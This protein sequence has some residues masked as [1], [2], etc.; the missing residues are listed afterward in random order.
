VDFMTENLPQTREYDDNNPFGVTSSPRTRAYQGVV[1]EDTPLLQF[2]TL[3][4]GINAGFRLMKELYFDARGWNTLRLIGEHWSGDTKGIYANALKYF[5]HEDI[6]KP[7]N[8]WTDG[9]KIMDAISKEENT[10]TQI[11]YTRLAIGLIAGGTAAKA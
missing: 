8:F 4:D 11:A 1:G 10:G 7:L 2:E 6:D 3:Q 9:I 5:S